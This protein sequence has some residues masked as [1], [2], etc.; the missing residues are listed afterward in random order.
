[1]SLWL[2]T[3]VG[4]SVR[5]C[6]MVFSSLFC[7]RFVTPQSSSNL[8]FDCVQDKLDQAFFPHTILYNLMRFQFGKAQTEVEP[9][10]H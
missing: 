2:Y 1:M 4:V 8:S 10:T 9:V 5:A 6:D 7:M 3:F